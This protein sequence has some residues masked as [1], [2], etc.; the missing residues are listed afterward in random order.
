MRKR[1][2]ALITGAVLW[3]AFSGVAEPQ[4][5]QWIVVTAPACRSALDPLIARHRGQGLKVV[6]IESTNALTPAQ[7]QHGDGA[8]LQA[9]LK[10]LCS[11]FHGV[12][13]IL[14]A[15][16]VFAAKPED[17]WQTVVPALPG[18]VGRMR[19]KPGDYAYCLPDAIGRPTVAVGRFP[20]A[21]E[22]QA[23]AMV[24]K[25]LKLEDDTRPGAWRNRLF[26]FMGD[27]GGGM[28]GDMMVEPALAASL[29]QLH[30]SWTIN[31][32][33]ASS[34]RFQM[35]AALLHDTAIKSLED[36]EIF[37]IFL[38]HSSASGIWLTGNHW[39]SRDDLAQA[40]IPRGAGVFFTCG[41]FSCQL[42]GPDGEGYGLAAI[43][44]P[45]GPVAVIG[46]T[47]ESYSAP[48]KLAL[49]GLLQT[50]GKPPFPARLGDYWLAVQTGLAEAPMDELTFRLLDQIDGT[51]GKV[52]LAVQRREHLEMWLLLGDPALPLPIPP[53]DITLQ[54]LGPVVAGKQITVNGTLPDRLTGAAVHVTLE[55]PINAAP[56]AVSNASAPSAENCARAN[57]FVLTAGDASITGNHF[58]CTL[59]PPTSLPWTNIILRATA[60][61]TN[62]FALGVLTLPV[63]R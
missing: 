44:N 45:A 57:N 8:A 54:A 26:L 33:S 9:Y 60:T 11:Q 4:P 10:D 43:R 38:D 25:T 3:T 52:P 58:T 46:A 34:S 18:T 16:A 37:S 15:G 1:V 39:I 63:G 6:V 47:G 2:L 51:Q 5:A 22:Q 21:N 53:L 14:L 62:E 30:P 41:C 24:E 28:M 29:A 61:T 42:H 7:I 32:E 12:N 56:A 55:R 23:R 31:A 20:A 35:P 48:G 59:T 49:E 36:G 40:R 13:F 50:L 19:D 17:A 27:P